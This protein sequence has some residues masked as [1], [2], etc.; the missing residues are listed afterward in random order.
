[1]CYAHTLQ[2]PLTCCVC[3]SP[4]AKMFPLFM[5]AGGQFKETGMLYRDEHWSAFA[6][7]PVA[8]LGEEL[9]AA[10]LDHLRAVQ[11][12]GGKITGATDSKLQQL[13]VL[14]DE[15]NG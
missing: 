5:S 6:G 1:M 9:T 12:A 3:A 13:L 11:Q 2:V 15:R 10:S 7:V 4:K 14:K 8:F